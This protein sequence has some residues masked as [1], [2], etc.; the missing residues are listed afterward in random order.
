MAPPNHPF[1]RLGWLRLKKKKKETTPRLLV[2]QQ[3]R[4]YSEMAQ[5]APRTQSTHSE[6]HFSF[7][8]FPCT[9]QFLL[10]LIKDRKY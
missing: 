3:W 7:L 1:Q 4:G 9:S 2:P 6:I 8:P 10:C 5:R